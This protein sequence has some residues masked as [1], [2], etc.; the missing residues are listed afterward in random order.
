MK[1]NLPTD[2]VISSFKVFRDWYNDVD[3]PEEIGVSNEQY[4]QYEE[5]FPPEVRRA[6]KQGY[7]FQGAEL[8]R[9]E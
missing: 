1:K 4:C 7:L 3:C 8:I 9:N 5:L 6:T 2:F